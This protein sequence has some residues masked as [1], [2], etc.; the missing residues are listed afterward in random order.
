MLDIGIHE[1]GMVLEN[2]DRAF[3][4]SQS[5][6]AKLWRKGFR[7]NRERFFEKMGFY[8]WAH[9]EHRLLL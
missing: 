6:A 9:S 7:E 8:K 4:P 5:S 1:I 3:A 2:W